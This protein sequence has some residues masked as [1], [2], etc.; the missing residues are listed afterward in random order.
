MSITVAN[1]KNSLRIVALVLAIGVI[2]AAGAFIVIKQFP[3]L[4]DCEFVNAEEMNAL[5]TASL[6]TTKPTSNEW[7][8]WLGPTRDGRA[9]IGPIRG[10]WATNPPEKVWSTPCGAGF[11]SLA[12]VDGKLYTMDKQGDNER[13]LCLDAATGAIRWKHEYLVDYSGMDS[14]YTTGPR[15][16]PTVMNGYVVTMGASGIVTCLKESDTPTVLWEKKPSKDL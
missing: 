12:L 15:A 2:L 1:H 3:N 16:T 7:P 11:S 14:T 10:D 9:P 5:K 8:Q 13:I 6:T 4:F